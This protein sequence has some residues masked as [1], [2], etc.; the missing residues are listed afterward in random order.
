MSGVLTWPVQS[1]AGLGE[2]FAVAIHD[3]YLTN[4]IARAS[5]VMA[6]LSALKRSIEQADRGEVSPLDIEDL[7]AELDAEWNAEDGRH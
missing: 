2:P 4:P 3:Y 1:K 6:E 5:A 7:I